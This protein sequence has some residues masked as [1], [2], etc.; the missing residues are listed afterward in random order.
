MFLSHRSYGFLEQVQEVAEARRRQP[1]TRVLRHLWYYGVAKR[2]LLEMPL[3]SIDV[4]ID[5]TVVAERAVLVTVANVE[6]Y[7][8]FLSLTPKASPIDGRFDV[9]VM[10]RV[11]KLR[12]FYRLLKVMFRTPGCW[13]GVALYRGRRVIVTMDGRREELRTVRR[14]LPLLVPPGAIA[15]LKRRQVEEDGPVEES[16]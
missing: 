5:G 10:P 4:E 9:L 2:V 3:P 7:R 12:L 11:G 8:G 14:A 16:A 6:T 13:K 15:E 1:R